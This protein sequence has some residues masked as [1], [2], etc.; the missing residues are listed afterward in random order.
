MAD[1]MMRIAGRSKDGFAK[2][3]ATDDKGQLEIKDS[4]LPILESF[5][6]STSTDYAFEQNMEGFVISNDGANDLTIHILDNSYVV[7]AQE[8]FEGTFP[9][10]R[11]VLIRGNSEF[12]AY[13]KARNSKYT[14]KMNYFILDGVETLKS[15]GAGWKGTLFRVNETV[16]IVEFG[17]F[18]TVSN[19]KV[20]EVNGRTLSDEVY[21]GQIQGA[22]DVWGYMSHNFTTPLTLTANTQYIVIVQYISGTSEYQYLREMPEDF[23]SRRL[24]DGEYL[25]N[26]YFTLLGNRYNSTLAPEIGNALGINLN[27]YTVYKNRMKIK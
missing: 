9:P 6:G 20:F 15:T 4:D 24:K 14:N 11:G 1:K 10:F 2:A 8:V 27:D 23:R 12:R 22:K 17:A 18:G 21:S 26:D 13:G 25:N 7:R 19:V 5:S 3:I 16:E